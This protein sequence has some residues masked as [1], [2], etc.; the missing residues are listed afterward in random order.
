ML[1]PGFW[2]SP[3]YAQKLMKQKKHLENEL[4][5]YEGLCKGFYDISDMIELAEE[6]ED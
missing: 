2:D 5:Q 4:E 3:D 6:Y 1:R